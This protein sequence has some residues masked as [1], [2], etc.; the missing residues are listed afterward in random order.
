MELPLRTAQRFT[1]QNF[2]TVLIIAAQLRPHYRN[3]YDPD[4]QTQHLIG[5]AD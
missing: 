1:E 5:I 2:S 4:A 3:G